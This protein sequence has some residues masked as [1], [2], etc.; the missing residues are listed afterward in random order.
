M[1]TLGLDAL[2]LLRHQQH[3]CPHA[4]GGDSRKASR[5]SANREQHTN[6]GL[7]RKFRRGLQAQTS[8]QRRT[9]RLNA[10][11]L[12]GHAGG[13]MVPCEGERLA[14]PAQHL[15]STGGGWVRAPCCLQYQGQA[16]QWQTGRPAGQGIRAE[17]RKDLPGLRACWVRARGAVPGSPRS[18]RQCAPRIGNHRHAARTPQWCR[19]ACRC[20]HGQQNRQA[21][22]SSGTAAGAQLR[23]RAKSQEDM[24]RAP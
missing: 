8:K 3:T 2:A 1:R 20:R 17:T 22:C 12:L 13:L 16:G 7:C 19:S 21:H 10:F 5:G 14:V 23:W 9:L 24:A 18:C 15:L 4:G 11:A 6:K